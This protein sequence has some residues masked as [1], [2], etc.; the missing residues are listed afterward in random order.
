MSSEVEWEIPP[1]NEGDQAA[2]LHVLADYQT[3]FSGHSPQS[4]PLF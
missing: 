4:S 2:V 3:A 1:T